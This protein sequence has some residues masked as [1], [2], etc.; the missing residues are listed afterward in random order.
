MPE[1]IPA[2]VCVRDLAMRYGNVE[3]LRGI[4]FDVAAG[5]IFGLLG[6]NGAGK[7]TALEC[8]LGLRRQ[9]SGTISIAGI[10][11]LARPQ[12]AK[13]IVGALIQAATLQDRITPRKALKLFASFYSKPAEV[14]HLIEKFGLTNKAEAAFE[15]LSA[16]QRQRLFL[17]L[18]FVNNPSLLVLDEPTAG[19]DPRSRRDLHDII[20]EMRETGRTVLLSTHDIDEAYSL[21][22][23]IGILDHGRVIAAARPA[24]LIRDFRSSSSIQVRTT[25]PLQESQLVS[26]PCVKGCSKMD[27]GW[28]IG[29]SNLNETIVGLVRGVESC[30]NEFLDLKVLR[31]SLEDVFLS[32]TGTV[33][34]DRSEANK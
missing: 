7:T 16:G 8:I 29:T 30:G 20:A 24:D 9:D 25:R 15:T 31:P 22:D 4:S 32:L 27:D 1:L 10:D 5:E 6:P 19:L 13:Q 26:L 23:R 11:V 17:A 2:S 28:V 3:A 12:D 21:C 33:W 14:D 18:A 34:S